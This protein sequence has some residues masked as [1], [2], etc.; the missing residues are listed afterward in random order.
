MKSL[1][2]FR[3]VPVLL[4]LGLVAFLGGGCGGASV[5][6]DPPS[7]WEADGA[8]WWRQGA[9]TAKAFRDLSSIEA[10]GVAQEAP[11]YSAGAEI[12]DEQVTLAAK[13]GLEQLYRKAPETIDSLFAEHIAPKVSE[14]SRSG[15]MKKKMKAF[16]KKSH[17]VLT[18]Y[19]QAPAQQLTLGEDI[20]VGYPDS[21]FQQGVGGNVQMQV[22]I[23]AEGQPQAIKLLDNDA[24]PV[25]NDTA[26]RAVA[27]MRWEPARLRDGDYGWK[28]M[29]SWTWV[30]VGFGQS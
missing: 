23:D 21:L 28:P 15:D 3:F 1:L 12:T 27:Q 30:N 7:G 14:V 17:E 18:K 5:E 11:V 10:M 6:T 8:R 20:P 4:S 16:S 29:P 24:H 26:R 19:F 22:Y 13:Q 2:A 25:L 9:D